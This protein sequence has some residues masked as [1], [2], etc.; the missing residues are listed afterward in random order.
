MSKTKTLLKLRHL[1]LGEFKKDLESCKKMKGCNE[2]SV[3]SVK[4]K[5][6]KNPRLKSSC[7]E[8]QIEVMDNGVR[9]CR[10][11]VISGKIFISII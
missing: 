7:N 1:F 4:I 9:T 8:T 6:T 10:E 5:N 3:S 2:L 11:K